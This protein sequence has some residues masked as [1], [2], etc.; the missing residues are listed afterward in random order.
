MFALSQ[1]SCAGAMLDW[2]FLQHHLDGA[3][4]SQ[5]LFETAAKYRR[6]EGSK[7]LAYQLISAADIS[8]PASKI[9][10]NSQQLK[11]LMESLPKVV[12]FDTIGT[13][14]PQT[15]LV[16]T[17]DQ[18]AQL[19]SFDAAHGIVQQPVSGKEFTVTL[20]VGAKNWVCIGTAVDYKKRFDHNMGPN[21]FGMGSI[22]PCTYVPDQ[23]DQIIDKVVMVLKSRFRYQGLLSCQFMVDQDKVWFLEYNT[24]I[25]DPEFQSMAQRLDHNFVD[26]IRNLR[27]GQY[28]TSPN[29]N[30]RNAVTINLIHQQWP[31]RQAMRHDLD[32]QHQNFMIT[33]MQGSWD[34]NTYWGSVTHSGIADHRTLANEIY[35]WLQ[36]QNCWP[37]DYRTDIGQ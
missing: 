20:A 9:F 26:L 14:G 2:K 32:L 18:L 12:K 29:Q 24:R 5:W 3:D 31:S 19:S 30:N 15:C 13:M 23:I 8:I 6:L 36:T 35:N 28:L 22:A 11:S 16:S 34:Q 10:Q 37:F 27:S 17:V 33:K 21:T 1:G 7:S 4:L 25:C